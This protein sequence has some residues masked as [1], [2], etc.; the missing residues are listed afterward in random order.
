MHSQGLSKA[1]KISGNHLK[2][3]V[4]T[5]FKFEVSKTELDD[6]DFSEIR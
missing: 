6:A 2:I 1:E 3:K 4:L 5:G